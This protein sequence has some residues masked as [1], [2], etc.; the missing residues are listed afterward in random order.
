MAF[1]RC[2][3][4]GARVLGFVPTYSLGIRCG[5]PL[6]KQLS[7]SKAA[8]FG[9]GQFVRKVSTMSCQQM[10]LL[11]D[12]GGMTLTFLDLGPKGGIWAVH[13]SI[14]IPN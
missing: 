1:Q 10:T 2:P 5:L 14:T 13:H 7:L 3:Q 4:I 12:G 8:S 6:R 11:E 9:Q